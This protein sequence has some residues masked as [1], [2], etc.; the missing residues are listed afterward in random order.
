MSCFLAA[1]AACEATVS[2]VTA[3][4]S[5]RR[6]L[7]ARAHRSGRVDIP[8][9]MGAVTAAATH[10]GSTGRG[11]E[12]TLATTRSAGARRSKGLTKRAHSAVALDVG[13]GV[14]GARLKRVGLGVGL[15]A[16]S[17]Q[18]AGAPGRRSRTR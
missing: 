17:G 12:A 7:S 15:A 13:G 9:G 6:R 18:R 8:A 3:T 14:A 16:A 4:S 2:P 5:T 1:T 10:G 11:A